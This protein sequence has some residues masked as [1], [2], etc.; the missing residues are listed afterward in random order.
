MTTIVSGT[1][2]L[3]T[4][5]PPPSLPPPRPRD[6]TAPRRTRTSPRSMRR[7]GSLPAVNASRGARREARVRSARTSNR[8]ARRREALPL[9]R[10]APRVPDHAA[11]IAH[12]AGRIPGRVRD[13]KPSAASAART[14]GRKGGGCESGCSW[15]WTGKSLAAT[16]DDGGPQPRRI[17]GIE[18]VTGPEGA[19][20][21]TSAAERSRESSGSSAWVTP[22]WRRIDAVTG[23]QAQSEKRAPAGER[24]VKN[25]NCSVHRARGGARANAADRATQTRDR[26]EASTRS[27]DRPPAPPVLRDKE[28]SSTTVRAEPDLPPVVIAPTVE[29]SKRPFPSCRPRPRR[30]WP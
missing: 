9:L 16:R 17:G 3:T 4:R 11:A 25:L 19:E 6:R 22:T 23:A 14:T 5:L 24:Q 26:R 27:F 15:R 7:P 2:N 28:A 1:R 13:K 10:P 21:A 12:R 8:G 20:E 29:P 30:G 18:I